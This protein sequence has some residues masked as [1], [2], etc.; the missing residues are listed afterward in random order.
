MKSTPWKAAQT[1]A[2][3]QAAIL[4]L[5]ATLAT[6]KAAPTTMSPSV[7]RAGAEITAFDCH[8][9]TQMQTERAAERCSRAPPLTISGQATLVQRLTIERARGWTCELTR[10]RHTYYCGMLSYETELMPIEF[11]HAQKV[12]PRE[13]CRWVHE[14]TFINPDRQTA[15][16]VR[17]PGVTQIQVT[18][19]GQ[20]GSIQ[21]KVTC[22][23]GTLVTADGRAQSG[24]VKEFEYQITVR[25]VNIQ[26]IGSEVEAGSH[27]LPCQFK[28]GR[29]VAGNFETYIWNATQTCPLQ[30]LSRGAASV[31][32]SHLVMPEHNIELSMAAAIELN[33]TGCPPLQLRPTEVAH[34]YAAVGHMAAPAHHLLSAPAPAV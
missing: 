4:M 24:I 1:Q 2:A 30:Q 25:R 8:Q 23:G 29:C 34:V 20:G 17:V 14:R 27:H 9:P 11:M 19:V 5:V 31:S 32:G 22:H 12:H 21:N 7:M 33:I 26:K 15:H 28:H 3:K 6:S 16:K 13:C 18:A 10:S